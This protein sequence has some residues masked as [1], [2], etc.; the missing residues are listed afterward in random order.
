MAPNRVA[1]KEVARLLQGIRLSLQERGVQPEDMRVQLKSDLLDALDIPAEQLIQW[2][3]RKLGLSIVRLDWQETSRQAYFGSAII[4]PGQ[5]NLVI[6]LNEPS[7]QIIFGKGATIDFKKTKRGSL[8]VGI[9]TPSLESPFDIIDVSLARNELQR[10]LQEKLPADVIKAATGRS[11]FLA[12]HALDDELNQIEQNRRQGGL[13]ILATGLSLILAQWYLTQ[14]GLHFLKGHYKPEGTQQG[15][16]L[17]RRLIGLTELAKILG[18]SHYQF[19]TAD[20]STRAVFDELG[21]SQIKRR[22]GEYS[23]TLQQNYQQHYDTIFQLFHQQF[24]S[25]ESNMQIKGRIKSRPSVQDK[26]TR[27]ASRAQGVAYQ[28]HSLEDAQALVSDGI[29]L[30]LVLDDSSRK[31]IEA[32]RDRFAEQIKHEAIQILEIKNYR[33]FGPEALAYFQ[34]DDLTPLLKAA[35]A[36]PEH[37]EMKVVDSLKAVKQTGYTTAQLTIAFKNPETQQFD[38]PH[39]ELQ[40]RGKLVDRFY[41]IEH[42]IRGLRLGKQQSETTI[43]I[44]GLATG[45]LEKVNQLND[46]QFEQF[47][48]YFNQIYIYCRKHEV[49]QPAH[50]PNRP[51]GLPE[52]FDL[53]RVFNTTG[54]HKV[55][56]PA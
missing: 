18:I 5:K 29:G 56:I 24:L 37:P 12:H 27:K 33:G 34:S 19:G 43:D 35:Q 53:Q 4:K 45:F 15:N 47:T 23:A 41:N 17:V 36:C 49:G 54:K 20:G 2:A 8:D 26:L 9:Q 1:A 7:I 11:V 51:E 48:Y 44:P 30:C 22:A 10:L 50:L 25:F 39:C 40:I 14:A 21:Q 28:M 13:E 6:N 32:L 3:Q 55:L 16:E 42:R 46:H 52:L 38:L 31:S